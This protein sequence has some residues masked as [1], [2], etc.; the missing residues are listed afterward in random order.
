MNEEEINGNLDDIR[1]A[2][3][4]IIN[5]I[6]RAA[7]VP[8]AAGGAVTPVGAVVAAD[9]AVGAISAADV[10]PLSQLLPLLPLY[11]SLVPL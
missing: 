3:A 1:A 9:A 10:A 5:P 11:Q 4:L 6:V 2:Y 8:A 7:P